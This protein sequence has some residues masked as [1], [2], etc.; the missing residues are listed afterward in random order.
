ML[1]Y[2]QVGGTGALDHSVS[3][4]CKV[5]PLSM[6]RCANVS[7]NNEGLICMGGGDGV[8]VVETLCCAHASSRSVPHK[9]W[10]HQRLPPFPQGISSKSTRQGRTSSCMRRRVCMHFESGRLVKISSLNYGLLGCLIFLVFF[11]TLA[12]VCLTALY[13]PFPLRHLG[14][15][16]SD[17]LSAVAQPG[18]SAMAGQSGCVPHLVPS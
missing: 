1:Q 14:G 16:P 12:H 15:T 3:S 8:V 9:V 17:W 18:F 13:S 2:F 7:L 6:R 10:L 4:S 11:L 5:D